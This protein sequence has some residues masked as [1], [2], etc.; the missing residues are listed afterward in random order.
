MAGLACLAWALASW[1]G[2]GNLDS[3][4]DMLENYAWSQPLQWGS[5]KHPPFFAWMT[6]LWFAV[7]PQTDGAYRLLSFVNVGVGLW[8]VYALGRRLGLAA[9]APMGALLLLWS[10]PY[11]TLAGKFNANTQLLSLWPWTAALLVASWQDKGWRGL[12]SSTALGLLA[13][14]CML[15]KYY[16]GVF[17]LGCLVVALLAAE[18][19]S[20]FRT[21]RPY[22]ALA[23]FALALAPHVA[24]IA[25]H[26]WVTLGYAMNQGGGATV[27][28]YVTRFALA[29]LFYWLPAWLAVVLL[30]AC[31]QARATGGSWACT[32]LTLLVRSWAPRG[33]G[34]T[35]FWLALL[36]WVTT[37]GFGVAGVVELSTP[38]AIPIGYAYALL[39]L[40]NLDA[41]CPQAT[42]GVLAALRRAWLPVVV[43]VLLLGAAIGAAAALRGDTDYYRPTQD[44][45]QTLAREWHERHPQEPLAWVG[46][47]WAENAMI[48]FYALP[49]VR[50]V[51]GLPDSLEARLLGLQDWQ[52]R[53]GLL[54]CPRGPLAPGRQPPEGG[55]T[56]QSEDCERSARQWLAARGQSAQPLVLT[57]Q[58]QGWRFPHPQPYSYAVF[59][60]FP[61][62]AP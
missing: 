49:Q 16:S 42:L 46:G 62:P 52:A 10:F 61:R 1:L 23:V 7:F 12:W 2:N 26:E 6:G 11:T 8:G 15:S 55:A 40:R 32:S 4:H 44:A 53:P 35:L 56:P 27:W 36:P 41:L 45:A 31:A 3:Y 20:W 54:V 30:Y 39:W 5:H 37:L 33:W 50:T 14:A 38:W 43:A 21:P 58:R 28:R 57:V 9:L 59:D 22:W 51:P 24:W 25:H 19:R 18:G 17:L 29:P 60:V 13:A 34:D 48:G 47:A